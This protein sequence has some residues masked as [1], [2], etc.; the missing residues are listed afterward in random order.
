LAEFASK[1]CED[2]AADEDADVDLAADAPD[3]VDVEDDDG[4]MAVAE[5]DPAEM[6]AI[7]A[8]VTHTMDSGCRPSV[9]ESVKRRT[10][11]APRDQVTS[12]PT[13]VSASSP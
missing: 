11:S 2:A 10:T 9:R 8:K 6:T 1:A 5:P 12:F 13:H 7:D 3:E 4:V